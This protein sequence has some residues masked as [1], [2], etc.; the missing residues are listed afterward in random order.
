[1]KINPVYQKLIKQTETQIQI[2]VIS[3]P[4]TQKP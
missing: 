4:P 1:M 3:I 2:Q